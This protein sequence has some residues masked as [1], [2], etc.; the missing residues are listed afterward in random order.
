MFVSKEIGD[1][2][3]TK[4]VGVKFENLGWRIKFNTHLSYPIKD[5]YPQKAV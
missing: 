1:C 3:K 5:N 2:Y 4:L